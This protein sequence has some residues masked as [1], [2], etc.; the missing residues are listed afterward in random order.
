MSDQLA[1][2]WQPAWVDG[3]IQWVASNLDLPPTY[4]KEGPFILYFTDKESVYKETFGS[5]RALLA[6]PMGDTLLFYHFI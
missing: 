3:C 4:G 2:V 5:E 6:T 1:L